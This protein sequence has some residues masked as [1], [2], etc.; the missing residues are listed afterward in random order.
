M[1]GLLHQEDY[2]SILPRG[3]TASIYAYDDRTDRTFLEN[4]SNIIDKNTLKA[5]KNVRKSVYRNHFFSKKQTSLD[6]FVE[7][8]DSNLKS[9]DTFYS[10]LGGNNNM[11]REGINNN[12]IEFRLIFFLFILQKI[13]H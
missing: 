6:L 5:M 10:D 2:N 13:S 11:N 9:N 3:L 4:L 1:V 7:S 12:I 8:E